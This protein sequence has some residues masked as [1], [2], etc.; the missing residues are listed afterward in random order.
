ME[1]NQPMNIKGNKKS[2][3][4]YVDDKRKIRENVN[5]LCKEMEDLLTF[6]PFSSMTNVPPMLPVSQ[7]KVRYWENEE[8]PTVREDQVLDHL[9]M[10]KTMGSDEM[11]LWVLRQMTDEVAK[12]ISVICENFCCSSEAPAD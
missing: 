11:N 12:L 7:D 8:S 5:P 1:L 9:K 6:L 10:H 4:N 3:Y 2:F